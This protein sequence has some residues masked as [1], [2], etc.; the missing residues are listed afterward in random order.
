MKTETKTK[1]I[2]ENLD[3]SDI[4]FLVTLVEKLR[5]IYTGAYSNRE[6]DEAF[7]EIDTLY[8]IK[9][10]CFDINRITN[11]IKIE[12]L[13]ILRSLHYY[14]RQLRENVMSY[15][16]DNE[17]DG[18]RENN[19]NDVRSTYNSIVNSIKLVIATATNYTN[20]V[21]ENEQIY[22]F[23][24][25]KFVTIFEASP[26]DQNI[27]DFNTEVNQI[28]DIV[29]SYKTTSGYFP[30]VRFATNSRMFEKT[31][32]KFAPK[33]FHFTCHG[34]EK[35]LVFLSSK[36]TAQ[37]YKS[38]RLVKFLND[39][40]PGNSIELMYLNS[41]YSLS[42][43]GA[44]RKNKN[45]PVKIFKT[46]GYLGK[47]SNGYATDFSQIFYEN[48]LRKSGKLYVCNSFQDAKKTFVELDTF[49]YKNKYINRLRVCKR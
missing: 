18:V 42:F 49:N 38:E 48:L 5:D 39:N 33:I 36:G 45:K 27:I 34:D 37:E 2:I 15:S 6:I 46:I 44:L 30:I 20:A 9:I 28:E 16:E 26:V 8:A 11:R 29:T 1:Y 14:N 13:Y 3:N 7:Y 24:F 10:I 41:C 4:R 47:N 12:P 23:K 32:V 43:S 40:L 25:N 35:S 21:Y 19:Q 31:V 17:L 22:K